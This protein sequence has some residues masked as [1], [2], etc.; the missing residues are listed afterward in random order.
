MP[1]LSSL[2]RGMHGM[3]AVWLTARALASRS[4]AA[5]AG[6]LALA[7]G[8]L[9]SAA[10][11]YSG[12]YRRLGIRPV[13]DESGRVRQ[14]V[15]VRRAVSIRS[16][17]QELYAFWRNPEN[18]PRVMRH[19][20]LVRVID[21]RR[22]R[23]RVR[24]PAGTSFEWEA[25]I[26]YDEPNRE[27]RW[28]S[29]PG[30]DVHNAGV[31]RFVPVEGTD[32]TQLEVELEYLPPGGKPGAALARLFGEEP[33]QQIE[34]DLTRFRESVERGGALSGGLMPADR[35]ASASDAC[36]IR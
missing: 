20:E 7:G 30:A 22:S 11:G 16:P 34:D 17:A 19:L 32:W 8:A 25:A 26:T 12:I 35:V 6:L 3:A 29:M 31:V 4:R 23:W 21:E 27:I 13:R 5:Q 28:H 15:R 2:E 10:T 33:R 14:G 36:A 1:N 24:G 18:L 9:Y